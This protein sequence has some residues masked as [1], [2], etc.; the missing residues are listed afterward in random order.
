MFK[1]FRWR[2]ALWFV[3]L[4]SL[5]YMLL[6]VVGGFCFYSILSRSMDDELKMV[7]SQIGHAIDLS[8][9]RPTFRDWLRVVETEP[10]SF[11]Q[12]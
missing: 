2:I 8:G 10:A 7:A 12:M 9:E 11:C 3:G 1:S 6:S 4:S 5:V